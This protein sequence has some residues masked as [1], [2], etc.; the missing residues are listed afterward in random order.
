MEMTD[1]H[2]LLGKSQSVHPDPAAQVFGHPD[3]V[4]NDHRLAVQDKRALLAS[5][6]S[7]AN[8]VPHVPS[9]RQLPDGSIVKAADVLRA[10]KAL[11][12]HGDIASAAKRS[13]AFWPGRFNRQSGAL[14]KWSR[15]TKG[16]DDDDDPPPCPAY[17]AKPSP[18]SGGGAFAIPEAVAA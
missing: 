7:D 3:D 14:A 11:D 1:F 4:V 5:W 13:F 9:L 18:G 15:R 16:P 2:G 17:A 6:A 8:A 10:L 12:E